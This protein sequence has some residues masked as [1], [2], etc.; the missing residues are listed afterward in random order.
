[1]NHIFLS[2]KLAT[3]STKIKMIIVK[4]IFLLEIW[5]GKRCKIWRI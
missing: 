4:L 3:K 5:G 2:K 1:M